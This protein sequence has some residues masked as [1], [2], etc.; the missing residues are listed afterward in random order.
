[1]SACKAIRV[2]IHCTDGVNEKIEAVYDRITERA[3]ER[4]LSRRASGQ[5]IIEFWSAAER[6]LLCRPVTEVREWGHGVS[7]QIVCP[8]VDPSKVRLFMSST[9][10]LALAPINEPNVDRWL[11]QYLRFPKPLDNIDASAEYEEGALRIAA[12]VLNAP[13]EHKVHFQ[14]A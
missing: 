6:E 8:Q 5:P 4:W 13:D 2:P 12:T 7:V 10:L 3:Y 9:E 14:V 11:F 1:M